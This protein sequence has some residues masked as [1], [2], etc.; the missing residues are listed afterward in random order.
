MIFHPRPVLGVAGHTVGVE[1]R[2]NILACTHRLPRGVW[3][4]RETFP[5]SFLALLLLASRNIMFGGKKLIK[6]LRCATSFIGGEKKKANLFSLASA[7]S[8]N[9][10]YAKGKLLLQI[11]NNLRWKALAKLAILIRILSENI[12]LVLTFRC[13]PSSWNFFLYFASPSFAS[14]K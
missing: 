12:F 3:G 8:Q 1:Q 4:F 14:F 7:L 9:E 11:N 5:S 13:V 2:N 10:L 6:L